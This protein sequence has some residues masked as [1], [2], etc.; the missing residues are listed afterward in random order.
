[1]EDQNKKLPLCPKCSRNKIIN[2]VYFYFQTHSN[3]ISYKCL[4]NHSVDFSNIL[5]HKIN[6]EI[7]HELIECKI[8][9]NQRYCALCKK[10]NENICFLCLLDKHKDHEYILFS[11]LIL[12]FQEKIESIDN[13]FLIDKKK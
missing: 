7:I 9:E 6:N 13:C 10:C 1:M 4:K 8:H 3:L 2:I 5:F 12:S 11:D